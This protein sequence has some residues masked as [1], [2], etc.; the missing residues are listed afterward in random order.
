MDDVHDY[1][2]LTPKYIPCHIFVS[3][4]ASFYNFVSPV[5]DIIFEQFL[6]WSSCMQVLVCSF[7]YVLF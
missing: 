6:F 7:L 3:F 5:V 2:R 1:L 4:P